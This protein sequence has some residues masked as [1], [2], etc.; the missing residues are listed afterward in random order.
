MVMELS[1]CVAYPAGNTTILVE[2][3][4]EPKRYGEVAKQLLALPRTHAEQVGFFAAPK[5]GGAVRLEMMGGEF[6]GNAL[7]AAA[8]WQICKTGAFGKKSMAVEISGCDHPLSVVYDPVSGDLIGEMPL[9][10]AVSEYE[11]RGEEAR[12]VCF[13]GIVHLIVLDHGPEWIEEDEAK[14][15][16]R[17]AAAKFGKAAAG[18]LLYNPAEKML[19]PVVYV[20]GTDSL[21]CENSCASG[22]A[23]VAAVCALAQGDGTWPLA[24]AQPGGTL[25]CEARVENGALTALSVGGVITL[26]DDMVAKID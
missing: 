18:L 21:Y 20:V 16:L 6:C 19:Y 11:V 5:Q 7:R 15:L 12:A 4:V 25:R 26:T 23:A 24:I 8:L 2:T 10:Q 22:S 1:I 13:E 3:P 9:P 17:A 14:T